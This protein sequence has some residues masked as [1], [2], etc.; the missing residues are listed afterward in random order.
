VERLDGVAFGRGGKAV[1]AVALEAAEVEVAVRQI[2]DCGRL[3]LDSVCLDMA[4]ELCWH[5][6]DSSR[7]MILV[8]WR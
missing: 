6:S 5:G 2:A 1:G 8:F 7:K 3:A 4:A